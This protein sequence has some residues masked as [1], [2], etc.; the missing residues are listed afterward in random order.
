MVGWFVLV[1]L[2]IDRIDFL[3][4]ADFSDEIFVEL[5]VDVFA[6]VSRVGLEL[7]LE[8]LLRIFPVRD[9]EDLVVDDD[10]AAVLGVVLRDLLPGE[11]SGLLVVGQVSLVV[12]RDRLPNA[13][14]VLVTVE[15]LGG[16]SSGVPSNDVSSRVEDHVVRQLVD[17]VVDNDPEI[18][19]LVV[20]GDLGPRD[21]RFLLFFFLSFFV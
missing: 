18:F 13:R 4:R 6:L 14:R 3:L 2:C 16:I 7:V 21:D 11:K 15:S 12:V 1:F 5:V 20:L 9:V 8:I 19:E 10:P 17:L